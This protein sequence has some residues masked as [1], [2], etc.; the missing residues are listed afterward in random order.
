M[1]RG[2]WEPLKIKLKLFLFLLI[3]LYCTKNIKL[4]AQEKESLKESTY[5]STKWVVRPQLAFSKSTFGFQ[6]NYNASSLFTPKNLNDK[7]ES[8]IPLAAP[9]VGLFIQANEFLGIGYSTASTPLNPYKK[10]TP[11]RSQHYEI[12]RVQ[13]N[14]FIDAY[15]HRYEKFFSSYSR[16]FN[17][18]PFDD[19]LLRHRPSAQDVKNIE[20]NIWGLE[21]SYYFKNNLDVASLIEYEAPPKEWGVDL[22]A[23]GQV[24]QFQL[25]SDVN[26]VPHE[27]QANSDR[28]HDFSYLHANLFGVGA[29]LI[30]AIPYD[31]YYFMGKGIWGYS[32]CLFDAGNNE[33]KAWSPFGN[34]FITAARVVN[35]YYFGFSGFKSLASI[36][37]KSLTVTNSVSSVSFFYGWRF[38]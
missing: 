31:D 22:V 20:A 35:Q 10:L 4:Y 34:L 32:Y 3:F 2:N 21:A 28:E 11:G 37:L 30:A 33:G 23:H 15:Y 25:K 14:T 16:S 27:I 6:Q 9:E 38:E 17:V 8:Y 29:G 5:F 24:R 13:W 36:P 19:A 18:K 7:V 26:L 12:H 1:R